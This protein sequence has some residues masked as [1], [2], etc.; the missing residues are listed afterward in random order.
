MASEFTI[1]E[2]TFDD[3]KRFVDLSTETDR[4]SFAYEDFSVWT[5]AFGEEKSRFLAAK[6]PGS[7]NFIVSDIY[8]QIEEFSGNPDVEFTFLKKI[9]KSD[10]LDLEIFFKKVNSTSGLP[11]FHCKVCNLGSVNIQN[12]FRRNSDS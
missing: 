1:Q 2:A 10:S 6:G 4:W 3:W 9:S 7:L 12:K 11:N 5:K 8:N